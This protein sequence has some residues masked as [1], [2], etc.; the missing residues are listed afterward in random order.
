MLTYELT[1]SDIVFKLHPQTLYTDIFK[2]YLVLNNLQIVL[3][4]IY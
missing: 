4:I 1:E 3:F 2:Y